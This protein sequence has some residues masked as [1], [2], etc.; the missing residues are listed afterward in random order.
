MEEART[1]VEEN[2]DE[3]IKELLTRAFD[4]A[5][6]SATESEYYR[7]AIDAI[8]DSLGGIYKYGPN[9]TLWFKWDTNELL[10]TVVEMK[11]HFNENI[12]PH[13]FIAMYARYRNEEGELTVPDFERA[14]PYPDKKDQGEVF[15][16]RIQNDIEIPDQQLELSSFR[17][18]FYDHK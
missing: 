18:F 10:N 11:E 9:N 16:Q 1:I 13:Y 6:A 12:S 15:N 3:H 8:T 17:R 2:D 5:Y 4:D 14:Y 7:L